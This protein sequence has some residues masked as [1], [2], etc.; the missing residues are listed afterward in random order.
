MGRYGQVLMM[1]I[2]AVA[3]S[4]CSRV[5]RAG[6]VSVAGPPP[7]TGLPIDLTLRQRSTV[8]VPGSK[9]ALT[10]TIDDVTRGQVMV[11][12]GH[13]DGPPL[14]GPLSMRRGDRQPVTIGSSRIVLELVELHN[15]LIGVDFADFRLTDGGLVLTEDQKIDALI[16]AVASRT[17]DTFIRNGSEHPAAAAAEHL[18]R[19]RKAVEDRNLPARTFIEEVA[20]RSSL[21]GHEYQ[22]RVADGSVVPLR[23]ILLRELS[24]IESTP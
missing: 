11:T 22:V 5:P 12:V 17:G 18:I 8:P 21:S 3:L 10:L 15:A 19:K 23:D 24:R 14:L 1:L 6:S 2:A 7:V 16:A 9:D 20:S 13:R 4:G